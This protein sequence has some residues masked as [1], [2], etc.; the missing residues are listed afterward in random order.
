[1]ADTESR[2]KRDYDSDRKVSGNRRMKAP[3]PLDLPAAVAH[4]FVE[5]A[6]AYFDEPDQV[7]RDTIAVKQHARFAHGVESMNDF[8]VAEELVWCSCR[9]ILSLANDVGLTP[10]GENGLQIIPTM[11]MNGA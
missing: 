10:F 1:M 4:A 8:D 3:K 11:T 9:P 6:L 5:D 2:Q 7:K